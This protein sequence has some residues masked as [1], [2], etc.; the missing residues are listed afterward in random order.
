MAKTKYT[1]NEKIKG[2]YTLVYDGKFNAD[3]S[4]RRKKIVSKKSSAD[5]EKKVAAFKAEVANAGI[6]DLSPYTFGEY[7]RMWRDTSKSTREQNTKHMY[8]IVINSHFSDISN[9]PLAKIN[10]SHFQMCINAHQDHPRTCQ[11]ISLTFKQII[12]S[13][14]RDRYLPRTAIEDILEDISLPTYQKPLKRA[15]TALE[16]EAVQK[17]DLDPKKRCFISI[18]YYCGLR[19]QEV[20]A[21]TREDFDWDKKTLSVTKAWICDVNSPSI[22]PYP[23]SMNGIREVPIPDSAIPFIKPFVETSE[24]YIFRTQGSPLM[25]ESSYKRM[26]SSIVCSMNIALGYNPQQKKDKPPRPITGLTAHLFRHNYCTELCY[27][28]PAISTKMI[29]KLLGDTEKMVLDVYSHIVEDREATS[30]AINNCF[31]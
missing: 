21:L 22:K 1:Y 28:V 2:W 12:K 3:G 30:E 4:K 26:W 31:R 16:K 29:A 6:V 17:A 27:Q 11:L 13:A 20:L 10:H 14:V 8:D 19:K 24:G 18:L 23:K 5:L 15:L 7:A 25:T 9:I